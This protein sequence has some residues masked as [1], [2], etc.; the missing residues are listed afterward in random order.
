MKKIVMTICLLAVLSSCK[1]K[2]FIGF[3]VCKEYINL[4]EMV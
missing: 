3:L 4:L 2:P 1:Q